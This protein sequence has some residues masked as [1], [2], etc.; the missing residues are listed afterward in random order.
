MF[1]NQSRIKGV[2]ENTYDIPFKI[3]AISKDNHNEKILIYP[4]NEFLELFEIYA[5]IKNEIRVIL[6]IKPQKFAANFPNLLEKASEDRK[7]LFNQFG[8]NLEDRGVVCKLKINEQLCSVSESTNWPINWK[9][10]ELRITKSPL[11]SEDDNTPLSEKLTE[12]IE[13]TMG[14]MLSLLNIITVDD[15][16]HSEGKKYEIVTSRYER[17]PLNRKLCLIKFG[18]NCQIC[19]FNFQKY[20]GEIGKDFIHVH[21]IIPVSQMGGEYIL[22]PEKDLIPLCPNCHAM[23]HKKNPPFTPDELK[24]IIKHQK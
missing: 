10:F 22:N 12:Y 6:E 16:E 20:Y 9:K 14:M 7:L 18:Y 17:N 4:D 13:L 8:K 2:L 1:F 23:V 24:E 3:N 19:G 21:H 5:E 15:E 11:Q